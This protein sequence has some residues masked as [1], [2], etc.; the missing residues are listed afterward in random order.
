MKNI[1]EFQYFHNFSASLKFFQNKKQAHIESKD[2]IFFAF[3]E[4]KVIEYL[5][6]VL[7]LKK[8]LSSIL[9]TSYFYPLHLLLQEQGVSMKICVK[10]SV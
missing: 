5:P 3:P 10:E 1:E 8:I 7:W 2:E 4:I 6:K 9:G